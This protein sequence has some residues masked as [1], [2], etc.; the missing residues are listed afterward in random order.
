MSVL[1]YVHKSTLREIFH[2]YTNVEKSLFNYKQRFSRAGHV[3][4]S[5][6]KESNINEVFQKKLLDAYGIARVIDWK[7]QLQRL[8]Q[9]EKTSKPYTRCTYMN[10]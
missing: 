3:Y 1:F 4:N 5:T 10:N 6:V 7:K 8:P 9:M 2:L